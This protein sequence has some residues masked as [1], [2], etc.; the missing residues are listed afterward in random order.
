MKATSK[1]ISEFPSIRA[2]FTV[3]TAY[4][5]SELNSLDV[6]QFGHILDENP[7]F[8]TR[9]TTACDFFPSQYPTHNCSE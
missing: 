7:H 3:R 6:L 4:N 8:E 1:F 9:K 2:E 5:S